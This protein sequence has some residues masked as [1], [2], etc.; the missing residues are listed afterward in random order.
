MKKLKIIRIVLSLTFLL[1]STALF[2]G[3][4]HR[5]AV[6]S[7]MYAGLQPMLALL[8]FNL[9]VL[10]FW[11]VITFFYGRI[12]CSVMC[13]LGVFQDIVARLFNKFKL[14]R[15]YRYTPPLKMVG[16]VSLGVVCV[17]M[18]C[19]IAVV[20]AML[21]PNSIYGRMIVSVLNPS[22]GY[23][24]TIPHIKIF[25]GVLGISVSV[26]T[27][28]GVF[29]PS[30]ANGRMY[31]NSICP[32]GA[33]LGICS[34]RAV[35]HIEINPD[36]CTACGKCEDVCKASCLDLSNL[37]VDMSRCVLC[38]NCIHECPDNAIS[39]TTVRSRPMTPLM[40]RIKEKAMENKAKPAIDS[41][42]KGNADKTLNSEN[43]KN[44][45]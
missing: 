30:I 35:Y 31:C 23:F 42:G 1:L 45:K 41:M 19:G 15:R 10:A 2:W 27:F 8:C 38:F 22:M 39:Y 24:A 14:V 44:L 29:V 37:T 18:I 33:M 28:I 9:G 11:L 17:C 5:D 3:V 25:S 34:T 40:Q 32:V 6:W 43:K 12:Y 21:D 7:E 4:A 36:K 13:P 20:P 26:L 16:Y